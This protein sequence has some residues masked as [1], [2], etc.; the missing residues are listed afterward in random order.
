[1]IKITEKCNFIH[2]KDA[3]V[4]AKLKELNLPFFKED[5]GTYIFINDTAIVF[6]T[7]EIDLTKL[8]F[9]DMYTAS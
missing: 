4:A 6:D 3:D 1:M 7:K 5:N 9:T 8:V 2:T